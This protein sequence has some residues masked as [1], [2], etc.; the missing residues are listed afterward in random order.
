[1]ADLNDTPITQ[2][3]VPVEQPQR[4]SAMAVDRGAALDGASCVERQAPVGYVT[5]GNGATGATHQPA[6][7]RQA[8]TGAGGERAETLRGQHPGDRYVRVVRHEPRTLT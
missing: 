3:T 5:G 7:A 1:M 2:A 6:A 8:A 4:D